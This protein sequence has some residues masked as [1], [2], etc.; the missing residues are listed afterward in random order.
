MIRAMPLPESKRK[1]LNQRV[2]CSTSG[3][4]SFCF[5][6]NAAVGL[7]FGIGLLIGPRL[8]LG[9]YGCALDGADLGPARLYGAE[10]AST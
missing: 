6:A 4:F 10:L 2:G 9:L 7:A 3:T 8:L 1:N 5:W